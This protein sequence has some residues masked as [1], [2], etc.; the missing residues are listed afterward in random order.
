MKIIRDGREYELTHQEMEEAHDQI[1]TEFMTNV[2][3]DDFGLDIEK[4]KDFGEL[5]YDRYCEGEGETE[6]E[7]VE[8]AYDKFVE[9]SKEDEMEEE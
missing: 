1:V 2:L 8:W 3:I 7:C 6:Y 9:W 4:A 5:A